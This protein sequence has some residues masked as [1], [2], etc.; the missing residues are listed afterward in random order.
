MHGSAKI[1]HNAHTHTPQKIA[2]HD[3]KQHQTTPNRT[4]PHTVPHNDATSL[5]GDNC[6]QDPTAIELREH[7]PLW[8]VCYHDGV[9]H[10]S[11]SVAH[12]GKHLLFLLVLLSFSTLPTFSAFVVRVCRCFVIMIDRSMRVMLSRCTPI[13]CAGSSHNSE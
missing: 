3:T 12:R 10:N 11:V 8:G 1:S 5:L 13:C 6:I 7:V 2:T 9:V 4:K